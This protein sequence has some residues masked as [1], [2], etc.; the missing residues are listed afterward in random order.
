[1]K[2][3]FVESKSKEDITDVINKSLK[4]IKGKV[5]L[6]SSVQFLNQLPKAQ[7]L[8]KGS[9]IVGQVLGCNVSNPLIYKEKVDMFLFI[10]SAYFY[11]IYLAYKTKKKVLIANPMTGEITEVKKEDVEKYEKKIKG[12]QAKFLMSKKIGVIVSTKPG[13]EKLQLALKLG[14]PVFVC[15]E[16]DENEL[17]NFQMDYWINTACNRIEGKNIINLEDLPK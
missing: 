15:N 7:K 11:P 10:G 14:Y 4:K 8:V 9:V 2:I 1:M 6:V 17:E 5:G 3:M 12:K 16:V 13:Q